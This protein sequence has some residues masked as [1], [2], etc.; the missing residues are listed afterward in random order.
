MPRSIIM[1]WRELL[2][3]AALATM[4]V[5]PARAEEPRVEEV[6]QA[7]SACA[8]FME[9]KSDNWIGWRRDHGNGYGDYFEFWDN[10]GGEEP[11]VLRQTFLIDGIA[12]V[13]QTSCF[14]LSGTLAFVFTTMTSPN[15]AVDGGNGPELVREGRLYVDPKGNVFRVLGQV[16]QGGKKVADMDTNAYSLARGCQSVD[17]HLTLDRVRTNYLHEMGDI[18][19]THPDY[20]PVVFDWCANITP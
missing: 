19:G 10:D 4:L 15:V 17:L 13:R 7:W 1:R 11:S 8:T 18:E 2:V 6:R 3:F 9:T 20:D 12:L 14:R 16:M 5:G